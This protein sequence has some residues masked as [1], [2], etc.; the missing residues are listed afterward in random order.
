MY[1][2]KYTK[3]EVSAAIDRLAA[4]ITP[5]ADTVFL[6]LMNGGAWFA[7]ELTRRLGDV[8]LRIEYARLSSYEGKEQGS[9]CISYM[10]Q[11]EWRSKDVIV[12]DD[13]CDTGKTANAVNSYLAPY[14]PASMKL[15]T[16]LS[17]KGRYHLTEGIEFMSGIEDDSGDFFVGCGLDDN[18]IARNLPYI[19]IVE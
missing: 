9:L 19:G 16:L 10:P 15:I 5:S 11:I 6:V 1:R 7:H 12:L 4:Q 13:I 18:G 17:R 3:E 14:N 8:P 2:I